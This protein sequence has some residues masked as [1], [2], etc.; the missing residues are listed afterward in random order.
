MRSYISATL[1]GG[2]QPTDSKR[3]DFI[4]AV[5]SGRKPLVT[6]RDGRN[7]LALATRVAAKM[8]E[9]VTV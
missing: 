6:G 7:A 2:V 4:D 1:A 8:V 9:G 5:R 3:E